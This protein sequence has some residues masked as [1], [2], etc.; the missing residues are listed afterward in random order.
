MKPKCDDDPVMEPEP[1][2]QTN[3][4]NRDFIETMGKF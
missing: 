1:E 3:K 2:K 4:Q